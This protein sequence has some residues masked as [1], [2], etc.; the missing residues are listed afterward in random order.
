MSRITVLAFPL[1]FSPQKNILVLGEEMPK[2]SGTPLSHR[3]FF[4]MGRKEEKRS[5]GVYI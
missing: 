4:L 5:N 1:G 3:T 2:N